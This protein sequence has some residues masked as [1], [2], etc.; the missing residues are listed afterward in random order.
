MGASWCHF[1]RNVLFVIYQQHKA[2]PMSQAK[3]ISNRAESRATKLT[4]TSKETLSARLSALRLFFA[5]RTPSPEELA[6]QAE[7]R[8]AL[9]AAL[10]GAGESGAAGS[11][12]GERKALDSMMELV[13]GPEPKARELFLFTP[14]YWQEHNLF[15]LSE[16]MRE[17]YRGDSGSFEVQRFSFT[18]LQR[19][20]GQL[21]GLQNESEREMLRQTASRFIPAETLSAQ[22]MLD[23]YQLMLRQEAIYSGQSLKQLQK[24]ALLRQNQK[25]QKLYL[26]DAPTSSAPKPMP[27]ARTIGTKYVL[28]AICYNVAEFIHVHY[29]ALQQGTALSELRH[30]FVEQRAKLSG[31]EISQ[32]NNVLYPVSEDFATKTKSLVA[33]IES[34]TK[35]EAA[36][37]AAK[38]AAAT[39]PASA[40]AEAV[41]VP[42]VQPELKPRMPRPVV[43]DDKGDVISNW[44]IHSLVEE[45]HKQKP[46]KLL[47][48]REL[49]ERQRNI[50]IAI[51]SLPPLPDPQESEL[52]HLDWYTSTAE[53]F[54]R[55]HEAWSSK[56]PEE[57]RA[58]FETKTAQ[59]AAQASAAQAAAAQAAAAAQYADPR[60]Y[61]G[62]QSQSAP[63]EM[64]QEDANPF[65]A[66][67]P[68]AQWEQMPPQY[69][70]GAFAPQDMR[71][72]APPPSL[73]PSDLVPE[74]VDPEIEAL[75]QHFVQEAREAEARAA[76][77]DVIEA[78]AE[79]ESGINGT[80]PV[81]HS[82][83]YR[84]QGVG[85]GAGS[86]SGAGAGTIVA[87]YVRTESEDERMGR[88]LATLGILRHLGLVIT[89]QVYERYCA[90]MQAQNLTPFSKFYLVKMNLVRV[91]C[92]DGI[93]ARQL[94]NYAQRGGQ[95]IFTDKVAEAL[96]KKQML[97]VEA[98]TGTGKTFAYLIPPLLGGRKIL[99]STATK[100]LQDQLISKDVPSL[101]RM[102]RLPKVHAISLKGSSNYLCRELLDTCDERDIP[103]AELSRLHSFAEDALEEISEN[104]F[105]AQYGELNLYLEEKVRSRVAC[106]YMVCRALGLNCQYAKNKRDY[107]ERLKLNPEEEY[108]P[109]DH[110]FVFMSRREANHRDI[111]AIN[112]ALF[113]AATNQQTDEQ[114]RELLPKTDIVVFDEAHT[115]PSICRNF[116]T[117]IL[118]KNFFAEQIHK[119]NEAFKGTSVATN[120]GSFFEC[121]TT[122]AALSNILSRYV[123][124][125]G[126]SETSLPVQRLKYA[127][128]GQPSPF[129]LL[130]P[131]LILPNELSKL[132]TRTGSSYLYKECKA[133][134]AEM[135]PLETL[136]AQYQQSGLS[137][138]ISGG[139][140]GLNGEGEEVELLNTM[141]MATSFGQS[142]E[143]RTLLKLYSAAAAGKLSDKNYEEIEVL[144]PQIYAERL[145][146]YRR[147]MRLPPKHQVVMMRGAP[148][149]NAD[150]IFT[151]SNNELAKPMPER[152]FLA[153]FRDLWKVVRDLG[154]LVQDNAEM[155]RDK[156]APLPTDELNQAKEFITNF[157][158]SDRDKEGAEHWDY[159]SWVQI[160]P[161]GGFELKVAPVDV[162]ERLANT[163]RS[164][165]DKGIA[166]V[167]TSATITV[168][169]EFSKFCHDMGLDLNEIGQQIVDSPFNYK[170]N[171][172]LMV[173]GQ[174]PDTNNKERIPVC[175]DQVAAAIEASPGGVFFLTTSYSA[176]YQ[177]YDEL[178]RRFGKKR[179]ILRQGEDSV[180]RLMDTFKKDGKAILVGT[181]SFWEGVDVPGKALSLVII[182]KLPFARVNEPLQVAR[183]RHCEALNGNFFEEESLP[184]AIIK[185]RQGVGRLIRNESDRGALIIM[186][187]R[188]IS[189]PY[190]NRVLTSL[191]TM[192]IV[193][194]VS[195]V[196]TFLR[197]L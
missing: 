89:D 99:V 181:S 147:Q 83:R 108:N 190:G 45:Q 13:R 9:E 51:A 143:E 97:V 72:M 142:A 32:L 187:P 59:E 91:F 53:D 14:L 192:K 124:A 157:M 133:L 151:G 145:K 174:F 22:F 23:V 29:E 128:R 67:H 161:K 98:G 42:A 167:F 100:V 173:S 30:F 71:V 116:F 139:S 90:E 140:L 155:V 126:D 21:W 196:V 130:G 148:D 182:D 179:R 93:L 110:C 144:W 177:A 137:A 134:L 166:T 120:T 160:N 152:F 5:Q 114:G 162:R 70:A 109:D 138:H 2:R 17:E 6:S 176:T 154:Q 68:H 24:E 149:Y 171:A 73:P 4:I 75:H 57:Q 117:E 104:R 20:Y 82:A 26:P 101:K 63:W 66:Q 3:S 123:S 47:T 74:A 35:A 7:K 141:I 131:L 37:E 150:I 112:H 54:A 178:K 33:A 125:W 172:C 64:L 34:E 165:H 193:N 159:A 79:A 15:P 121:L 195:D 170:Q 175:V 31:P 81:S 156:N 111:V 197:S 76:Q 118:D 84:A 8:K 184:E 96:A 28:G 129:Q 41:T 1:D 85:S 49:E 163:M 52:P 50:S 40:G 44:E 46:K 188:I 36:A 191:P 106:D 186:D 62:P 115:L 39:A 113:F 164:L 169:R 69:D 194:R 19:D 38:A 48:Q 92:N 105:E 25:I 61:G 180:H 11:D 127:H 78:I 107:N 153:L 135:P 94:P 77:N 119:V 58:K 88:E 86:W 10:A 103:S 122:L 18:A 158:N 27:Y 65:R 132:K 136:R 185:L 87:K 56:L 16:P 168:G 43:R 102:L 55:Y 146:Q 95:V 12:D 80:E 183:Q 60:A 189:K